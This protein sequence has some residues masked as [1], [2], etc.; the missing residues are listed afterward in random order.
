M[1]I[2]IEIIQRLAQKERIAIK[3]HCLIRLHERKISVDEVKNVLLT[4]EI[5]EE[6]PDDYPLP[7]ALLLGFA[8]NN[9]PLHAVVA[10]D[11]EDQML[12]VITT[13]IPD[14]KVWDSAFQRREIK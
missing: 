12:W 6:Y 5:I 9:K 14:I 10:I 2:N 13:Y 11:V 7:S 1:G 3:Q 8:Q 4:G